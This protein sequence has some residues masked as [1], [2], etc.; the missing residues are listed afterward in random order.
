MNTNDSLFYVNLRRDVFKTAWS[1]KHESMVDIIK[2][3]WFPGN[4]YVVECSL[5]NEEKNVFIRLHELRNFT[6]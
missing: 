5:L 2:V 4:G 6:E 3:H 1:V